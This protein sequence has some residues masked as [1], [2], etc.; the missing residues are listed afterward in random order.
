VVCTLVALGLPSGCEKDDPT[1]PVRVS[2]LKIGTVDIE[3]VVLGPNDSTLVRVQVLR[4]D[5]VPAEGVEVSFSELPNLTQ[6]SFSKAEVLTDAGGWG[7]STYRPLS[8]YQGTVTL[9][10]AAGDDKEYATLQ[11]SS[12]SESGVSIAISTNSGATSLPADGSST[13]GMTVR[14]TTGLAAVP[15]PNTK[16][17]LTAGDQFIDLDGNGIFSGADQIVSSGDRNQDGR[18]DAEGALPDFVTTDLNGQAS[19]LYTA[20]LQEGNVYLKATANGVSKDFVIFQHPTSLQVTA[21]SANR[22]LL[23]D[24]V[25]STLVE[26]TV[27][28]WGGSPIGG[29][30]VRYVAGEPFTDV[31]GDGYFTAGVDSYQD[32]DGNGRWDAIGSIES[33]ATTNQGGSAVVSYTAGLRK[34]LVEIRA[35]TSSGSATTLVNLVAVPP[36]ATVDLDLG[37]TILPADGVSSTTGNVIARDINGTAITGTE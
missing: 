35:T 26:T 6:Q 19:F 28:N 8:G 30:I 17:I 24:G 36:A 33:V 25:S 4:G 13:I 34:G 10:V 3:R 9:R 29:V 2:D 1:A 7:S 5:G 20:G 15:L 22:E 27:L 37:L 21:L 18:W 14:L 23:A 12:S 32:T 11:V 31:D 16:V